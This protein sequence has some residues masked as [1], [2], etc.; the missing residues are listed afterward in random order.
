MTTNNKNRSCRTGHLILFLLGLLAFGHALAQ[1]S[2][3]VDL[4]AGEVRVLD[5]VS[6]DRVAVGNGGIIRAEVLES[7]ELL[8]IGLAEG[9]TSLHLWGKDGTQ[10]DYNIHVSAEDP[11][12]RLHMQT[13]VRMKV[14]IIEFRK[15]ALGK[16]GIDWSKEIAGPSAGVI[17]DVVS[18]RLFRP[19][20]DPGLGVNGALPTAIKPFSTYLGLATSIS[21]RINFLASTG[22][23]I[24][25]AEPTLSCVNGGNATF[26]SGGEVPYPVVGTNGQV[27]VEFKE[28]GI[29]LYVSP[30]ATDKGEIRTRVLTE[31]SQIDPAVTVAGAPGLLTRRAQTEVNVMEG[32]T[33]VIAGLLN[34]ENSRDHDKV[35]GLGDIPLIGGLFRTKNSTDRLTELAIFLTPRLDDPRRQ[36]LSEREAT[37][38]KNSRER[39]RA[40][41]DKLD[42]DLM[43]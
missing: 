35:K 25:L 6:V 11:Q 15:S 10:Q 2:L 9:S 39:L 36:G 8:V 5:K 22:D 13:M 34:A 40:V 21:S 3:N 24:I 37:L 23:A 42:Y 17:G 20:V 12:T 33:I 30:L 41:G 29:R 4:F 14:K 31:V 1:G 38:Y 18:S 16:L 7:G 28:Y 27:S 26:L 32:Q 43:E 19:P